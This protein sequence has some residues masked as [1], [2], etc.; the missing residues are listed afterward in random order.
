MAKFYW[1]HVSAGVNVT[2]H[3]PFP[4]LLDAELWRAPY[5]DQPD[6]PATQPVPNGYW[7]ENDTDTWILLEVAGDLLRV[8]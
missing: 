1:L 6:L 3:G 2:D 7:D 5:Y 4:S 8:E